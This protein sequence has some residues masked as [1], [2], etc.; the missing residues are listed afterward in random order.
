MNIL[1]NLMSYGDFKNFK[2]NESLMGGVS[3]K[4]AK[5]FSELGTLTLTSGATVDAADVVDVVRKAMSE[6]QVEWYN[7][8]KFAKDGTLIFTYNNP[9]CPTM[10]VDDKMQIVVSA[11]FVKEHLK[12]KPN[13]VQ[14]VLMHEILHVVLNHLQR[15]EIWLSENGLTRNM[16]THT[17]CNLAADVE[18]NTTLV[19]C[20][21]ISRD[22]LVNEIHGMFLDKETDGRNIYKV[23]PMEDILD[24]ETAMKILRGNQ[25]D[26][27]NNFGGNNGQEGQEG[28]EQ[29]QGQGQ[30]EGQGQEQSE[31]E[32]Q[33]EGQG[34]SK[35]KGQG[36]SKGKGEAEENDGNGSGKDSGNELSN[37]SSV[38]D[39]NS[40][41][42][43]G[44]QTKIKEI[45]NADSS[46]SRE[47]IEEIC[48]DVEN[49]RTEYSGD[50]LKN[51]QSQLL[52]N[53]PNSNL[54]NALKKS[55]EQSNN[56][57]KLW[58]EIMK[59][60]LRFGHR[61][62]LGTNDGP[63]DWFSRSKMANGMIGK[64]V[65]KVEDEEPQDINVYVDVSGSMDTELL[66]IICRSLV[67]FA[68]DYKYSAINIVPWSSSAGE[69]TNIPG[70]GFRNIDKVIDTIINAVEAGQSSTGGG[71]AIH[72]MICSMIKILSQPVK[73]K[74]DDMHFVISD[75]ETDHEIYETAILKLLERDFG[76]KVAR[77][78]A[79]RTCWMIYNENGNI[80]KKF[81]DDVK[82]GMFVF[83]NP[84][85][86]KES[87]K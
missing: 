68:K 18:V 43:F 33:G 17:D 12:M 19:N 39:I 44:G 30:G 63:T 69:I 82:L 22:E 29:G 60:F 72:A 49:S 24:D 48:K 61:P 28:Q 76:S 55:I 62:G 79:K 50:K 67:V 81:E 31:G 83:L 78:V 58:K 8:Y 36:K 21:I 37:S 38:G 45:L 3:A 27:N 86:V 75:G 73:K 34:K 65:L 10:Y 5:R 13:L 14:A 9:Q 70:K 59:K 74:K 53:C 26:N 11:N 64:R 77:S 66:A 71:T 23:V 16:E 85:I 35:G 47:E 15:E 25:Q 57:Q 46:Y 6:I 41:G 87:N 2:L 40:I 54:R 1:H 7:F 80:K 20:D 56:F 42:E 84:K 4:I 52:S 32:G 51:K